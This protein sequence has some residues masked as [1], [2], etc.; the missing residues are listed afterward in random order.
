MSFIM[1]K[2]TW[3]WGVGDASGSWLNFSLFS[4]DLKAFQNR[5][6]NACL[7]EAAVAFCVTQYSLRELR[8]VLTINAQSSRVSHQMSRRLLAISCQTWTSST[9]AITCCTSFS[10]TI[11]IK[12]CVYIRNG[13]LVW[14]QC[15]AMFRREFCPADHCFNSELIDT[16]RRSVNRLQPCLWAKFMLKLCVRVCVCFP[17][18]NRAYSLSVIM[19]RR[20]KLI[21]RL[22]SGNTVSPTQSTFLTWWIDWLKHKF[23]FSR[24]WI[25]LKTTFIITTWHFSGDHTKF[26]PHLQ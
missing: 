3:R 22:C 26:Y 5:G 25:S 17:R 8:A 2:E 14:Q 16:C 18:R 7:M 10:C 4:P 15:F 6:S 13:R 12:S 11:S 24:R 1:S 21:Y 20:N 9:T 23:R 19:G